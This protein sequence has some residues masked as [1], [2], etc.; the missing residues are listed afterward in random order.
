[1]LTFW[2]FWPADTGL[3]AFGVKVLPSEGFPEVFAWTAL[4]ELFNFFP[5]PGAESVSKEARN[6]SASSLLESPCRLVRASVIIK[7]QQ[8]LL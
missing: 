2:S 8:I 6:A 5:E 1:M 4:L 7:V 3:A